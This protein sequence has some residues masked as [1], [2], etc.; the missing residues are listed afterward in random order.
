MVPACKCGGTMPYI[1]YLILEI[2]R[3]TEPASS[4][5]MIAFTSSWIGL[6]HI[7]HAKHAPVKYAA[8]V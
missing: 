6:K 2:Y 8:Q 3:G 4:E 5:D 7:V 1:G